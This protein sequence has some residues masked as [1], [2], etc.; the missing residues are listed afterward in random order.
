MLNLELILKQCS[1]IAYYD[2]SIYYLLINKYN[3]FLT[4]FLNTLYE[5]FI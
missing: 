1:T 4:V 5:L 2:L 3:A